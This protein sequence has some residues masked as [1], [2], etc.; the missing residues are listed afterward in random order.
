MVRINNPQISII[1]P[2]FNS[3]LI[4]QTLNSLRLQEFDLENVEV[5]VVGLLDSEPCIKPT[6]RTQFVKADVSVGEARNLGIEISAGKWLVFLDSDCICSKK[7]LKRLTDRLREGWPVVGGGISIHGGSFYAT[8]YNIA[9]FYE[10]LDTLPPGPRNYLPTL[11]LAMWREISEKV[12]PLDRE[13]HRSEDIE[14]TIRIKKQGYPLY[15]E[16]QATVAH[17]PQTNLR[18]VL[19]KWFNTGYYSRIVRQRYPEHL[20][21]CWL[22]NNPAALCCLSPFI[23]LFVTLRIFWR[24]PKLLKHFYTLPVVFLTRVAWCWGASASAGYGFL[25]KIL[26][27]K[28][29]PAT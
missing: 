11:N 13:L 17:R 18:R 10:F 4:D 28:G 14:W 6:V 23:G 24:Y 9:T 8:C 20:E 25:T 16:P 26:S 19:I 29:H 1:I 27:P 12:G 7:W 15:F 5:I 21:T 2:V 22:L 3:P